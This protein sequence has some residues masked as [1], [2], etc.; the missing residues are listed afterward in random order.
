MRNLVVFWILLGSLTNL[1]GQY[2]EY[3]V[4]CGDDYSN[5]CRVVIAFS[6]LRL[7]AGASFDAKTIATIPYGEKVYLNNTTDDND[8]E[9]G[10]PHQ[11]IYTPDS[12]PGWWEEVSWRGKSGYVFNA[13]LGFE[14]PKATSD[15]YLGMVDAGHCW[16]DFIGSP[17]Y[18]FYGLFVSE[19]RAKGTIKKIT[20]TMVAR[21]W[22]GYSNRPEGV[23]VH[24]NEKQKPI[25][26]FATKNP[27]TEEGPVQKHFAA[28][29]IHLDYES[30]L[31]L[32]SEVGNK[33]S[34]PNSNWELTVSTKDGVKPSTGNS[35]KW[36]LK[37][38][39]KQN[40]LQQI[41][42]QDWEYERAQVVWSGDL[43]RDGV[44]DFLLACMGD[45]VGSHILFLSRDPG[46]GK[47]LRLAGVYGWGDC[48]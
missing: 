28:P 46:K 6:G 40:G 15:F 38:T 26:I 27:F 29:D 4:S 20:P 9:E 32:I 17:A 45:H 35:F 36:S 43:D 42:D 37:L 31:L 2:Q 41:L 11:F 30:D 22:E 33:L 34:I 14:I 23:Y 3:Q 16:N 19:D 21:L 7:R 18:N 24:V 13:Y 5:A 44:Q 8:Y 47:M 39:N 48:C 1:Q 12:I 10:E 25:F